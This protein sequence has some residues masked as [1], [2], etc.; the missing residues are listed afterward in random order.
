MRR[1][2]AR[3]RVERLRVREHALLRRLYD[4]YL[5]ELTAFGAS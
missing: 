3:L 5:E 2:P 1:A 4:A